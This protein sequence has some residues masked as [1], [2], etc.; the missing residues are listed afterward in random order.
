MQSIITRLAFIALLAGFISACS[1]A[2]QVVV[3]ESVTDDI[4]SEEIISEEAFLEETLPEEATV[5]D[6]TAA[7]SIIVSEAWVRAV[8]AVSQTTALFMQIDN[9]SDVDFAIIDAVSDA[10]SIVELHTH[11]TDVRGVHSMIKVDQVTLPAGETVNLIPGDLH[12]M[13]IDLTA[14]LAEGDMVSVELI[15]NDNTSTV[16]TAPVMAMVGMMDM[17]H[18]NMA[19]TA[20]EEAE[21]ALEEVMDD[22][23]A[24]E[25]DDEAAAE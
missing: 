20:S 18:D 21:E 5:V 10:A 16:V 3:E 25:G 17:D 7:D 23:D 15:F 1:D 22:L 6:V 11:E 9:I 13:L 2:P 19:D 12:V 8:P 4:I 24:D 14:S